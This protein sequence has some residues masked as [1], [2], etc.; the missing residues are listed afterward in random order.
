[1]M[2]QLSGVTLINYLKCPGDASLVD[3]TCSGIYLKCLLM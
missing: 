3:S 2:I 1:M